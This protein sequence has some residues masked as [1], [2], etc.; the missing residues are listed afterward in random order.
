MFFAM[1]LQTPEVYIPFNLQ[2]T[3]ILSQ[4]SI[5]NRKTALHPENTFS[6]NALF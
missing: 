2:Y 4:I 1:E 6:D 5:R 3:L